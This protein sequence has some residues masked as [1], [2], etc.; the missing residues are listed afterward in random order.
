MKGGKEIYKIH[1]DYYIKC[2]R[3]LAAKTSRGQP[4]MEK[5]AEV[6]IMLLMDV[7]MRKDYYYQ[8]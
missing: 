1:Y 5:R 8:S 6:G 2:Y 7:V 4:T 3:L